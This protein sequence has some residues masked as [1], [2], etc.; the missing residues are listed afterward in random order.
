M[1]NSFR[2]LSGVIERKTLKTEIT[3]RK[4]PRHV[5]HQIR[6]LKLIV[7][8][9]NILSEMFTKKN[10]ETLMIIDIYNSLLSLSRLLALAINYL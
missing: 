9:S 10:S 7:A 2:A 5:S 3:A 1:M 8:S 6:T 4:L